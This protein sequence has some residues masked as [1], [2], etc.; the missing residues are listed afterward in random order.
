MNSAE[1]SANSVSD[2]IRKSEADEKP[3]RASQ[4]ILMRSWEGRNPLRPCFAGTP[5]R[6][7]RST[8]LPDAQ[9]KF[10]SELG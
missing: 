3:R 5:F 10:F 1:I 8:A 7:C 4:S 6:P 2:E 9:R